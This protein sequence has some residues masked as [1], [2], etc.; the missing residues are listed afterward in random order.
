MLHSSPSLPRVV[1]AII[2][3]FHFEVSGAVTGAEKEDQQPLREGG[4]LEVA[5]VKKAAAG[6]V[7]EEGEGGGEE[8]KM[9]IGEEEVEE[10][11]EEEEG[12]SVDLQRQLQSQ[13]KIHNTIVQSILPSLQAVLTQVV[14]PP[15]ASPCFFPTN[16]FL[17]LSF[18][19]SL[20][21]L[22]PFLPPL[23]PSLPP[24]IPSLPQD[25]TPTHRLST[26]AHDEESQMLRVPVAMAMTK[27]L[28]VLPNSTLH[29]HL[30]G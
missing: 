12:N 14:L 16:I 25:S 8:E 2:D 19:T 1:A 4:Q 21:S 24:S 26:K 9:E 20:P 13:Q 28:L 30:P 11:E 18:T 29:L 17:L 23:S 15:P 7:E 10:E 6:V 5:A 22:P 27:L 3:A